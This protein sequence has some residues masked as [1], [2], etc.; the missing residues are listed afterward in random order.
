MKFR[1]TADSVV[2]SGLLKM[3]WL[4]FGHRDLNLLLSNGDVME[5]KEWVIQ[6]KHKFVG[7]FSLK[8]GR[9]YYVPQIQQAQKF[10]AV[11]ANQFISYHCNC[12]QGME[13]EFTKLVRLKRE[14]N[15]E[16]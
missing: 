4:T 9:V 13:T 10:T 6:H 12:N 8:T 1:K 15:L 2:Y 11:K 16:K 14:I 5:L 3:P 7:G